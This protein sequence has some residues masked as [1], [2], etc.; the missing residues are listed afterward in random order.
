MASFPQHVVFREVGLRGMQLLDAGCDRVCIADAVGFA[1]PGEVRAPFGQRR[2]RAGA[3]FR[4]RHCH[5]THCL[6]LANVYAAMASG[7]A[8]FDAMLAGLGGCPHAPGA[9]GNAAS[10]GLAFMGAGMGI[11]TGIDIE[12][13]LALRADVAEWLDGEALH[14]AL[15]RAGLPG[16]MPRQPA[17]A[18][19]G[20]TA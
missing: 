2:A 5:D 4:C 15:W 12:R 1:A 11:D 17:A 9:S 6:A 19:A 14:G 18:P 13:L 20:A 10:E 16:T 8:R 7:V 3:K